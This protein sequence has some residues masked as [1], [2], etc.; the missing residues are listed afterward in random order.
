VAR[1]QANAGFFFWLAQEADFDTGASVRA[2]RL[3]A[4]RFEAEV[5]V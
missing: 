2:A 5:N 1:S 3:A 4:A